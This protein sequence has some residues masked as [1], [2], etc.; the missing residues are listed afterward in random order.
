[1]DYVKGTVESIFSKNGINLSNISLQKP[2]PP[3]KEYDIYNGL[4][5]RRSVSGPSPGFTNIN[6][7][8]VLQPAHFE[9]SGNFVQFAFFEE[10]FN[11]F[12]NN[13]HLNYGIGQ[14]FAHELL[15]QMIGMSLGY[16]SEYGLKVN[17]SGLAKEENIER[18]YGVHTAGHVD[19]QLNL[20][21]E[22]VYFK[23]ESVIN[24]CDFI[25]EEQKTKL[26]SLPGWQGQ[27]KYLCPNKIT[28][29]YQQ[30]EQISP[31]IKALFTYFKIMRSLRETYPDKT[32]CEIVCA[33][34]ILANTIKIMKLGEY[35]G[36]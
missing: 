3:Y 8:I 6:F 21:L 36:F 13:N 16:F 1:M 5:W 26:L 22:G 32:S 28:N 35:D 24:P 30:M 10:Y 4:T 27:M 34:K 23:N 15:H 9:L 18:F 7:S 2:V 25:T 12:S 19:D 14:H 31:G 20:L 17:N 29:N 11:V 33:S